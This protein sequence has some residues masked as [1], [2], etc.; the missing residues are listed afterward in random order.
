MTPELFESAVLEAFEE[1]IKAF[2]LRHVETRTHAPQ[3]WVV[4]ARMGIQVIVNLELDHV[5]WTVITRVDSDGNVIQEVGLDNVAAPPTA[6]LSTVSASLQEQAAR[7][8]TAAHSLV[9]G[10][11]V[12]WQAMGS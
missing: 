8:L 6:A 2:S 11:P 7:L 1:P 12:A 5:V 9:R 10:D 4:L 3:C